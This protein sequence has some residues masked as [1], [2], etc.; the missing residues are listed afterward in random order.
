MSYLGLPLLTIA[1]QYLE[2]YKEKQEQQT[3]KS[4]E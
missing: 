3:N 4:D 1:V 2:W